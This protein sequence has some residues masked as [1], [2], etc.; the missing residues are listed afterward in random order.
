MVPMRIP[1]TQEVDVMRQGEVN[2]KAL[3]ELIVKFKNQL[4]PFRIVPAKSN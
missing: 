2:L 3:K 4:E 1:P